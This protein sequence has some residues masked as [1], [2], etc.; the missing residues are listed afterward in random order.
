MYIVKSITDGKFYMQL[1]DGKIV[2][3]KPGMKIP[4]GAIV[5]GN[6]NNVP[7]ASLIIENTSDHS[8]IVLKGMESQI[9]DASM[10]TTEKQ[11]ANQNVHEQQNIH[12]NIVHENQHQ[13]QHTQNNTHHANNAHNT[14]HPNNWT[15]THE[16]AN[17][18]PENT[19]TAAGN[20][21][22]AGGIDLFSVNFESTP[23]LHCRK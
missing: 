6:E 19:A 22:P 17:I 5:F 15:P 10:F 7:T 21:A 1:P 9:F 11:E 2:E 16:A 18:N 23:T 13:N 3:L 14:T 20:N 12:E 8:K 4:Q